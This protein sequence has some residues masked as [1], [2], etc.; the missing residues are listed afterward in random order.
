MPT[1]SD[2]H[3][4]NTVLHL[5][6]D[7]D[8]RDKS[9][10]V[11]GVKAFGN[12]AV[13]TSEKKYGAGSAVFDGSTGYLT[14]L[15]QSQTLT[16]DF[17]VELW[18][19]SSTDTSGTAYYPR[20]MASVVSPD[21]TSLQIWLQGRVRAELDERDAPGVLQV[22]TNNVLLRSANPL[23]DGL[24]HHIAVTRQ[25]GVM[26]LFVDG[27][28]QGSVASTVSFSMPI[29]TRIGARVDNVGFYA[30]HIDDYRITVGIARYTENFTPPGAIEY[31][32]WDDPVNITPS[33]AESYTF[34]PYAPPRSVLLPTVAP[35]P[36]SG[37]RGGTE[38][39][40]RGRIVGTVKNKGELSDT[41]V[42]R[43]VRLFKDRDGQCVAE[44]WSNPVTG[45]Y[46]FE[47]INPAH[48]Y[49]ALSYDHTGQ[50]RAVVADNLTPEV[51]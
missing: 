27:A 49:T 25:S 48:K 13:S 18:M 23:N 2:P 36:I 35:D 31:I 44:T 33:T 21:A 26:R 37:I 47:N 42:Y 38:Y 24:W 12:V 4:H 1:P 29:G 11:N 34:A 19:R 43:R 30:G 3:Y 45:A 41:P 22:L 46:A 10:Y 9:R 14:P 6:F 40:G 5:P 32:N 28:S 7:S 8:L 39:G 15:S 17:C 50:F 20:L 51:F 16:G